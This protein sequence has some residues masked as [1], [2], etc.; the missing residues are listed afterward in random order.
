MFQPSP[1]IQSL[2]EKTLSNHD[3][4]DYIRKFPY[5]EYKIA[6]VPKL[7]SFYV[8]D[9]LDGIKRRLKHGIYWEAGIAKILSRYA[10]AN[11]IAIDL[12]AHV[13][14][15]T[16][17]M[18]RKVGRR[19]KVIAFEPQ[20]KIYRELHHNLILNR[21]TH[22]VISLRLAVG[23]E[24]KWVEMTERDPAN[25]GMTTI[26]NGGDPVHMITLDSLNLD[27]IS[28]LKMDIE[29]YEFQVLKGA[30]KTLKR[31]KPVIV[32]EILGGI[33]LDRCSIE[34]TLL[35]LDTLD[36]LKTLGYQ[37]TRISNNDFLA[38]PPDLSH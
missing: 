23:E 6:T 25:E 3:L 1:E 31:C 18:S 24:E 21:C 32:F 13:G 2:F 15:H 11:T 17:L 35:Y 5:D 19:G 22:N 34:H 33:D 36:F 16:I 9:V 14:I 10:K 37:V 12:G 29:S 27:N 8:D 4:D 20:F 28:L 30:E 26:G 38:I 7:G